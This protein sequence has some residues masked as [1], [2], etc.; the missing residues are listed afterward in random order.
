M[1]PIM[2]WCRL[3]DK[4]LSKPYS[5]TS[6]NVTKMHFR[7]RPNIHKLTLYIQD[8]NDFLTTSR[9]VLG[10]TNIFSLVLF[11]HI[12]DHKFCVV[13]SKASTQGKRLTGRSLKPNSRRWASIRE[14]HNDYSYTHR[15][16]LHIIK[17]HVWR[18]QALTDS[19]S[20]ELCTRFT[21]CRIRCE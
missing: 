18:V 4:S 21:I 1:L 15:R 8:D 20:S 9:S 17:Q 10:I 16:Y 5:F 13:I 2:T 14:F 6:V 3:D 19:I 11:L 12:W 7:H